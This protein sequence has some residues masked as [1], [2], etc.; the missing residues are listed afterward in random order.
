M[1]LRWETKLA[2]ALVCTS[3]AIYALKFLILGDPLNTYM[4]VMNSAGFLPMNV[5][6]V[7]LFINQMLGVRAKR[8]RLEKLN[9]VI[10]TFFSHVGTDLLKRFSSG[11]PDRERLAGVLAIDASW[12]D[13]DFSRTSEELKG[14]AFVARPGGAELASLKEFLLS[15]GDFLL[16][17]LENPALLEHGPFTETLRAVFHLKDELE[18]RERI[19]DLPESDLRHLHGDISRAYR[20]LV[21]QWLEYM[22]YQRRAYPYLFS[23]AARTNPFDPS[24]TPVVRD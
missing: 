8:E 11:D 22:K 10:G 13:P 9:M 18:R 14:H 21:R 23:L 19:E 1:R 15:R 7:T 2:I 6:F 5:L 24:S 3:I 17:L 4:Y 12:N 20:E 16:R